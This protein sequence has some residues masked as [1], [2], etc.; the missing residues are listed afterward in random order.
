MKKI[1][2]GLKLIPASSEEAVKWLLVLVRASDGKTLQQVS[3]DKFKRGWY[4]I[5]F[6]YPGLH[7]DNALAHGTAVS[8]NIAD[9]TVMREIEPRLLVPFYTESGWPVVLAPVVEEAWRRY[10]AGDLKD[11]EFYCSE[12]AIAGMCSQNIRVF[13]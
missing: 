7:P 11:E 6:L 3:P 8:N 9:C 1:S 10:E 13:K 12:A 2:Y 5:G 4:S